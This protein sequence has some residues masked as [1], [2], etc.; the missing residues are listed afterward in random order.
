MASQSDE[1]KQNVAIGGNRK[2]HPVKQALRG[3]AVYD[4][5]GNGDRAKNGKEA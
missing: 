2:R 3:M 5:A 4:F 1:A